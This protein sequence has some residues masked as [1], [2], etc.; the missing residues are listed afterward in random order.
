MYCKILRDKAKMSTNCIQN[1][2]NCIQKCYNKHKIIKES[3]LNG[4]GQNKR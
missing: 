3:D 1:I 4:Y 2:A